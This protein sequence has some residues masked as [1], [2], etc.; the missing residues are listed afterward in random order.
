MLHA[1][2]PLATVAPCVQAAEKFLT[3]AAQQRKFFAPLLLRSEGDLLPYRYSPRT[4]RRTAREW[5]GEQVSSE[6]SRITGEERGGERPQTKNCLILEN[7]A[8]EA[9][10]SDTNN[11]FGAREGGGRGNTSKLDDDRL[12]LR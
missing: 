12:L 10:G 2:S 6:S 9:T 8:T 5:Q 11:L 4:M 3:V 7:Y 1:F